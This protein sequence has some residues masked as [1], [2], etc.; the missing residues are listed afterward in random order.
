MNTETQ[1]IT[2]KDFLKKDSTV[3]GIESLKAV[4]FA[5]ITGI[6]LLL[7]SGHTNLISNL[8]NG[9]WDKNFGNSL[10]TANTIAKLSYL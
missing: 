1:R 5:L 8:F 4:F 3:K 6:F 2:V 9:F 7:I 10:Y